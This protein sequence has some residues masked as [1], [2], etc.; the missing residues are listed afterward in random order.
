[1]RQGLPF[2]PL[3]GNTTVLKDLP[4]PLAITEFVP[5]ALSL[6][7]RTK[8]RSCHLLQALLKLSVPLTIVSSFL[9]TI[10]PHIQETIGRSDLCG[11]CCKHWE[12]RIG[13]STTGQEF[14]NRGRVLN[15]F[16]YKEF[17]VNDNPCSKNPMCLVYEMNASAGLFLALAE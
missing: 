7:A 8:P 6:K 12:Y 16:A 9:H 5:H 2:A 17:E 11:I 13:L 4:Q 10:F 14:Q 3:D 15:A 1:M